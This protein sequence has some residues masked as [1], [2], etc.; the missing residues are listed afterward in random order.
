MNRSDELELR[1]ATASDAPAL[2]DL[3]RACFGIHATPDYFMWKYY[4]NP[5]GDAIGFVADAGGRLAAFYGVI[6]EPWHVG[7]ADATVYQSMDTMTH[8]DFQRRGLFAR[9]AELTYE[10]IGQQA[11]PCNLVGIAGP[12][13]LPGFTGKLGWS[14][15]HEFDLLMVPTL[16]VRAWPWRG[17]G[18]INVETIERPD[19]RVH[20]VLGAVATPDRAAWP[21]L[22]GA[23]FDWRVFGRSPKR[24]RVALASRGPRPI[25]ICVYALTSPRTTL[26]SY[27]VGLEDDDPREWL[28][29]VMRYV[30]HHGTILYTWRPQRESLQAQYKWLGFRSNRL[31]KGPLSHR[32]P[33]IVRSDT[34]TVNGLN[35]TDPQLFDLQPLMQ[36]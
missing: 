32:V 20:A 25:G 12:T 13:S 26:I 35:W 36:D 21:R 15:I 11:G 33:L 8:P 10:H 24:F 19:E 31:G 29:P 23:F 3:F 18:Q 22:D 30:A 34:G 2:I 27:L 14:L 5:A 4:R 6:P 17:D 1:P 28:P 9:L 16:V 7:G